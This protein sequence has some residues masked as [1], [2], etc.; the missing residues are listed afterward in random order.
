[1]TME[2][3]KNLHKPIE[4][5]EVEFRC[6]SC[7]AKYLIG[8]SPFATGFEI[9]SKMEEL[10]RKPCQHCNSISIDNYALRG[11]KIHRMDVEEEAEC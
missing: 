6:R 1:M 3:M 4:L 7:N 10:T 5:A 2:E 11:A 9:V 8:C